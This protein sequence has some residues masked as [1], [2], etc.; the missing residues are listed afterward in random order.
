MLLIALIGRQFLAQLGVFRHHALLFRKILGYIIIASV[1]LIIYLPV[2]PISP[3]TNQPVSTKKIVATQLINGLQAPYLAPEIAGIQS[4]INSKP[5]TMASLKDKV[6]LIDFWTY[7]CINCIRT[8]PY[9]KDWY[10]KY[11]AL[12]FEIIGVHSPEFAFEIDPVNVANAVKNFQITYPV[13]LDNHFVTWQ[14]FNNHYWPAHYLINKEGFVV[15]EH[16]GEGEYDVTENNIRFLIGLDKMKPT[17]DIASAEPSYN[18]TPETYL[19]YARGQAENQ[20]YPISNKAAS[21]AAHQPLALD[22][23]SLTGNW[24]VYAE[25]IV[26]ASPNATVNLHYSAKAVYAVMGSHNGLPIHVIIMINGKPH[27]DIVVK[28]NRLYTLI[29][30]Q[31]AQEN[32]LS[33]IAKTAGLE[34]Y[35]FTFG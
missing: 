9:L 6:V 8:L 13:A 11:H 24:I 27:G 35:T 19:G 25:K 26:A 4:W 14:N 21:Y 31:N 7:S 12:G 23:W 22:K 1:L 18:I 33:L 3:S 10:A 20:N 28:D 29:Q 17:R 16:F 30:T 32:Q 34:V 2:L 15:Y 5:L